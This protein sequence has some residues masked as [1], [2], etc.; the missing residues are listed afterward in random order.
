MV[1][2]K[3][4]RVGRGIDTTVKSSE[5]TW[6]EFA[7]TW[8]MVLGHKNGSMSS[9]QYT[10]M[11]LAILFRANSGWVKLRDRAENNEVWVA[12]YCADGKFCHT[13]IIALYAELRWPKLFKDGT[14]SRLILDKEVISVIEEFILNHKFK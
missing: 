7:P 6:R 2:I 14:G 10:R 3:R 4:C 5:A 11:Y 1:E 12:C 13:L 9:V 8:P